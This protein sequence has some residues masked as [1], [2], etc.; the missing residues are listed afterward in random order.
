MYEI[1]QKR[2]F[3]LYKSSTFK[4]PK[5][6]D[7]EN[8]RFLSID[9]CDILFSG[10]TVFWVEL[11]TCKKDIF[12]IEVYRLSISKTGCLVF[13]F[14]IIN[15]FVHIRRNR[16]ILIF[17]KTICYHAFIVDYKYMYYWSL[18]CSTWIRTDWRHGEE[19]NQCRT[20]HVLWRLSPR[21]IPFIISHLCYM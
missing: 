7:W 4:Y 3:C 9:I 16:K 10:G 19:M 2:K 17:I 8:I 11:V 20:R 1:N 12:E 18:T 15:K 14:T 6:F 5:W 21:Q 13:C